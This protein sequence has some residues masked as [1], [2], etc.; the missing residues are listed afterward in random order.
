MGKEKGEQL[1]EL[2]G[3][4]GEPSELRARTVGEGVKKMMKKRE[5]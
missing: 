1:N 4:V 2:V 3:L 5:G